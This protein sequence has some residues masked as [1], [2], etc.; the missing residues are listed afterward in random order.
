MT[1]VV[2][3]SFAVHDHTLVVQEELIQ[4]VPAAAAETATRTQGGVFIGK[5][6]NTVKPKPDLAGQCSISDSVFVQVLLP[7]A[8]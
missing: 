4:V 7:P 6:P 3:L 5:S 1:Q 2:K 8:A